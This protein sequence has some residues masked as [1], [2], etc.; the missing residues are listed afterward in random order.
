MV[1]SIF[2]GKSLERLLFKSASMDREPGSTKSTLEP[3]NK[4]W[5]LE[6]STTVAS[7]S[8]ITPDKYNFRAALK[9]SKLWPKTQKLYDFHP[10]FLNF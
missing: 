5:S 1:I 6:E 7:V 2:S 10:R 9:N 8:G 4:T 3:K